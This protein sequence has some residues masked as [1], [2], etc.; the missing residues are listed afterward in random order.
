M[1]K[2][3]ETTWIDT[4]CLNLLPGVVGY[5]SHNTTH[6]NATAQHNARSPI[7]DTLATFCLTPLP[8]LST[9]R[10]S[11]TSLIIFFILCDLLLQELSTSPCNLGAQDCCQ[12]SSLRMSCSI[13]RTDVY[14]P[15]WS[16]GDHM[17]PTVPSVTWVRNRIV[18]ST[19]RPCL[20]KIGK[21]V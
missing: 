7:F 16:A 6:S 11:S 2:K 19:D 17:T 13:G 9:G 14:I 1:P 20:H 5:N 21:R 18:T 12:Y 3:L 15:D 10:S 8:V 4:S